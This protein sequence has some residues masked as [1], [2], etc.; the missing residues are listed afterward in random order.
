M[1][2]ARIAE[3]VAEYPPAA[4]RR[5]EQ[6]RRLVLETAAELEETGGVEETLKWSVPAFL[7]CRPRVGTTVRV[8]WDDRQP[9][10]IG[11]FFPCSTTL[12]D[13][14]RGRFAELSFEGNRVLWLP[15][16]GRLPKAEVSE[17]L[18][19]ALTYHSRKRVRTA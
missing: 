11:V 15:L 14:L 10:R 6:L 13:D 16:S 2:Q 18:A 8:H 1:N 12:V 5:F 9:Q 7:P 3:V 4:R 17:C 19:A